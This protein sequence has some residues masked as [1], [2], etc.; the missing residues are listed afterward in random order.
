MTYVDGDKV[1]TYKYTW[2]DG[3]R[4]GMLSGAISQGTGTRIL[5]LPNATWT[6]TVTDTTDGANEVIATEVINV[7]CEDPVLGA[8]A[9]FGTCA[10]GRG[11]IDVDLTHLAGVLTGD[12]EISWA[13]AVQTC[14]LY[15]SPSP[16]D[17]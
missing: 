4:T 17:S 10:A 2:T 13:N 7:N 14:L 6:V 8:T 3:A 15:T 1:A 11:S 12:Y 16:R 9:V 5:T